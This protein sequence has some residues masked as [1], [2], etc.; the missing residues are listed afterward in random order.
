MLTLQCMPTL[1]LTTGNLF[2]YLAGH[3]IGTIVIIVT[4]LHKY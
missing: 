3:F 1:P 4:E 2:S